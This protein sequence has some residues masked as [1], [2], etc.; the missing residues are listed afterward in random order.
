MRRKRSY[1]GVEQVT[2][3]WKRAAGKREHFDADASSYVPPLI[4]RLIANDTPELV[5]ELIVEVG[6]GWGRILRQFDS[7]G[8]TK[9]VGIDLTR[10]LLMDSKQLVPNLFGI[11]QGD[12]T[13][14]PLRDNVAAITYESR[15]L[16]YV[17]DI[18]AAIKEMAR[19]TRPGGE[20]VVIQPNKYNPVH[21]LRY[22]TVL[23][24]PGLIKAGFE[25]AGLRNPEV[26]YFGFMPRQ[27]HVGLVES[28]LQR[29]PV[30]R[31]VAGLFSVSATK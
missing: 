4:Q 1:R 6:C 12:I 3:F 13:N 11:L 8:F 2:D 17:D 26:S 25:S 24:T 19:V 9:L 18:S 27:V 16:Q 31:R 28:L 5:D 30:V 22:H 10:D 29:M 14:I 7:K 21:M 20:V 23:L 15:V